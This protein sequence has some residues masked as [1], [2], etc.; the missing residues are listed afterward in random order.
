MAANI[1][2]DLTNL[3]EQIAAAV[4][5]ALQGVAQGI[6]VRAD[7]LANADFLWPLARSHYLKISGHH[8]IQDHCIA[9]TMT[10]CIKKSETTA[11]VCAQVHL[12]HQASDSDCHL[13]KMLFLTSYDT[14]SAEHALYKLRELTMV[15]LEREGW[16]GFTFDD[17]DMEHAYDG[18]ME[19]PKGW[20]DRCAQVVWK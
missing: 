8:Y 5:S 11:G 14:N 2:I 15:M 1:N 10:L 19:L 16:D 6:T 13:H 18:Y 4:R 12:T 17:Q 3:G 20:C 9:P 7:I